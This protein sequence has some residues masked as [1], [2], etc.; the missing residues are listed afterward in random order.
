MGYTFKF[1]RSWG[2]DE[3][4]LINPKNGLI[5]G[6]NDRRRPAGLAQGY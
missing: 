4:I 3:A 2:A 6:A 5:E 1:V